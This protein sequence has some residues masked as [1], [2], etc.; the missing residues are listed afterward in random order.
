MA[1]LSSVPTTVWIAGGGVLA[2]F[3]AD[4]IPDPKTK[5][6]V[7]LGGGI[8][9]VAAI[10]MGLDDIKGLLGLKR[11]PRVVED[12]EA[13]LENIQ[14]GAPTATGFVTGKILSP[15]EGEDLDM[16]GG[17]YPVSFTVE[18][19]TADPV[20][21][22]ISFNS[23]EV[24]SFGNE[25]DRVTNLGFYTIGAGEVR[26]LSVNID[27]ADNTAFVNPFAHPEVSLEL[28]LDAHVRDN[29]RFTYA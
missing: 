23:H 11:P 27:V 14:R 10:F 25:D 26:Q 18:N 21:V 20:R 13:P 3:G 22:H 4:Y 24:Y 2:F 17:R 1:N 5:L 6:V 8:A 7:K 9:A 19:T 28:R 12:E 15:I 16:S 29:V